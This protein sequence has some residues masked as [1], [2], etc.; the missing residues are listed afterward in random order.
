MG[1]MG[2]VTALFY[3][4]PVGSQKCYL[5]PDDS[6]NTTFYLLVVTKN[7]LIPDYSHKKFIVPAYSHKY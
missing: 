4:L 3:I 7:Y 5:V 1:V 2:H 6:Y